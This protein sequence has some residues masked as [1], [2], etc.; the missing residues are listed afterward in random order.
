MCHQST[1]FHFPDIAV[2]LRRVQEFA[3]LANQEKKESKFTSSLSSQSSETVP[4]RSESPINDLERSLTASTD[5]PPTGPAPSSQPVSQDYL[6][7]PPHTHGPGYSSSN[8]SGRSSP[9]PEMSV[10][11]EPG[12]FYITRHSN[13]SQVHI[14]MHLATDP[15]AVLSPA[16]RARHPVMVGLKNCLRAAARHDVHHI[17]LPLLLVHDMQP[18]MTI[19]WC[20]KRS[21]LVF[22]CIKGF[23]LENSSWGEAD[24]RTIQ[25]LV[26]SGISS[27]LFEE[28]C[29]MLPRVFRMATTK[30]ITSSKR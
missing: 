10:H 7:P 1:D 2:Q 23:M 29:E 27:E 24:S 4:I 20:L 21:E 9:Q 18:E 6:S 19:T 25:F 14:V 8:S 16:L 22:K 5:A 17:T 12:D 11:L 28:F 26:P 13:L 3:Q 15:A 30:N